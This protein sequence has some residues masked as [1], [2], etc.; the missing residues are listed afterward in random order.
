[1]IQPRHVVIF[2]SVCRLPGASSE[3]NFLAAFKFLLA[4]P[5]MLSRL[6][7]TVFVFGMLQCLGCQ[8]PHHSAYLGDQTSHTNALLKP[9]EHAKPA[10]DG[11]QPVSH[12]AA[13][14]QGPW[15]LQ[16]LLD[17]AGEA[18]PDLSAARAK[19]DAARGQLVQA[20]L[21]PNPT[22]GWRS[23]EVSLNRSGGGQQGPYVN[24]EIVTGGKLSIAQAAAAHGV[25]AADWAA[26]TKW[27]DLA[28]KIRV[29]YYELMTAERTLTTAKEIEALLRSSVEKA[30]KLQID[31]S[32]LPFDVRKTQVEQSLSSAKRG[33]AERRLEAAK[34]KLAAVS[35]LPLEVISKLYGPQELGTPSY[36]WTP[37]LEGMLARSSEIQEVQSQIQQAQEQIRLAEAQVIPNLQLQARPVYDFPDRNAMLFLEA[38]IALPVFNRNQGNIMTARAELARA[39]AE[40]RQTQLRLTERL[41]EAFRRYQSAKVQ[42]AGLNKA[43]TQGE[44]ALKLVQTA[45]SADSKTARYLDVLDAQR[46]LYQV[47][48]EL[49]ETEGEM[50]KAM[51]EVEG[52]IQ[53][54]QPHGTIPQGNG[55]PCILLP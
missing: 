51:S 3:A 15:N 14:D 25:T 47:K 50:R 36:E 17:Q 11:I 30:E 53:S 54:Q 12:E 26:T 49:I 34:T 40:L 9:D 33:T 31:G 52:L 43:Q 2:S 24:Q 46:T 20:G 8:A 28:T 23:E 41:S 6:L 48:L 22:V 1:M 29:A 7:S 55:S 38:G 4:I 45:F 13:A 42:L 5:I 18:H 44:E 35:G 37:S 32:M 27:Y 39:D 10:R 21:Y 19:A 16:R